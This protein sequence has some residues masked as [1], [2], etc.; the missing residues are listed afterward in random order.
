MFRALSCV[1]L[2]FQFLFCSLRKKRGTVFRNRKR[3][4]T[5]RNVASCWFFCLFSFSFSYVCTRSW[6]SFKTGWDV[7]V[8]NIDPI[9]TFWFCKISSSE[10]KD[11]RKVC[12]CFSLVLLLTSLLSL[13]S[14]FFCLLILKSVS[15]F[16]FFFVFSF[17]FLI[18][19]FFF[20][21]LFPS[22]FLIFLS[23]FRL[24]TSCV[25]KPK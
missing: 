1:F 19:S 22:S 7:L 24:S 16:C 14:P 2:L 9:Q 10:K 12:F 6:K 23:F 13:S 4:I 8:W 3:Q 5:E 25:S 17:L 15:V 18:S 20:F 21:F 11:I